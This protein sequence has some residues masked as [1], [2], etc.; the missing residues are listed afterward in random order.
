MGDEDAARLHLLCNCDVVVDG[1]YKQLLKDPNLLWR[2]SANQRIIDVNKSLNA[3]KI[4][5]WKE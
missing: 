1:A 5:L 2:G 3:D 4:V